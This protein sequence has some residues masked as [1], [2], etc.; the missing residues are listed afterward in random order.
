MRGV[1][2]HHATRKPLANSESQRPLVEIRGPKGD[3]IASG[4][5]A[6]ADSVLGFTWPI[7]PTLVGGEYTIHVSHPFSGHP[8]AE[9]KFDVRTFRTPRLKTQI[10]FLRDGYGAG[11]EVVATL[12][13]ERAEGGLPA[14]SAVTVMARVDGAE[15]F[16]GP[17]QIDAQGNCQAPQVA[18]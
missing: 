6:V 11:D 15:V 18:Q 5:S 12:H 2:L 7:P 16:Q 9:R 8:P 14:G 17:A 13:A 1:L 3:S 4:M 10:K